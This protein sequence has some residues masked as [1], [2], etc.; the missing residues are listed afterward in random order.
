VCATRAR[1]NRKKQA[2][3]AAVSGISTRPT[4]ASQANLVVQPRIVAAIKPT[5]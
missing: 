4:R 2:T 3:T 5:M 1:Q